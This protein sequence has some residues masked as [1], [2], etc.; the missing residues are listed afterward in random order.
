MEEALISF[1]I[2]LNNRSIIIIRK[3][4]IIQPP[5][6]IH[7]HPMTELAFI[8]ATMATKLEDKFRI[9]IW[10]CFINIRTLV[11]ICWASS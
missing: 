1:S 10:I 6:Y 5:F 8:F 2:T 3:E 11:V 4:D 7:V 9:L